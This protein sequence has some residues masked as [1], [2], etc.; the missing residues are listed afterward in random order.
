MSS[1]IS[2]VKF[3]E[4]KI[5]TKPFFW[6]NRNAPKGESYGVIQSDLPRDTTLGIGGGEKT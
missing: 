1:M 6:Y 3:T 4:K 5:N 2:S